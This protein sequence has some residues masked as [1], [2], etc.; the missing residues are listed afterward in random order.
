M[1]RC[2]LHRTVVCHGVICFFS[3]GVRLNE[4]QI[5]PHQ[6][7]PWQN[8]P[9]VILIGSRRDPCVGSWGCDPPI[10]RGFLML[11]W[12]TEE[13]F[14]QS[15]PEIP[16]L[17][18]GGQITPLISGWND[19]SYQFIKPF[20][21]V[22]TQLLHVIPQNPRWNPCIYKAIYRGPLSVPPFRTTEFPGPRLGDALRP[23]RLELTWPQR[24]WWRL[25]W[26]L[27][28]RDLNIHGLWISQR[29]FLGSKCLLD[30]LLLKIPDP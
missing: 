2:F 19:P 5:E 1:S 17:F 14:L 15:A 9:W 16:V 27:K 10:H 21:G 3:L 24:K 4:N 22:M 20:I 30:M 23:G 29:F 25:N 13:V 12:K 26:V 18:V 11:N 28:H 8:I 6:Q 7:N